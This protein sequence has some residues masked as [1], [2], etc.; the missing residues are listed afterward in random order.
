MLNSNMSSVGLLTHF[1]ILLF[2]LLLI[3]I[4]F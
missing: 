3:M 4:W 2:L 1:H